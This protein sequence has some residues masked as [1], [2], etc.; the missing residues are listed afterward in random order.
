[1]CERDNA[2]VKHVHSEVRADQSYHS[3]QK[4]Y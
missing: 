3:V 2:D 1:M 4:K